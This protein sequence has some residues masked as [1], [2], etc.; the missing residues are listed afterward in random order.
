MDV[1]VEKMTL[2]IP[3]NKGGRPRHGIERKER[4]LTFRARPKM[5]AYLM[6]RAGDNTR[7]MSEEIEVRLQRT[8]DQDHEKVTSSGFDSE[9]RDRSLV[10]LLQGVINLIEKK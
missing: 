3:K 10:T 4:N 7:S 5:R 8:I 9:S 1:P 2:S 6:E